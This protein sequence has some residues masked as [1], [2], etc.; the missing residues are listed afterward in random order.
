MSLAILLAT[1]NGE[2]FL[3]EQL[4][5]L[6]AQT[7]LDWVLYVHDDGSTDNTPNI[8]S[9]YALRH[10]NIVVMEYNSS[11]GAM[12]NFLG[13]LQRIDADY[14]MFTDQ[15]DVWHKD[16]VK[17]S[18]ERIHECEKINFNTPIIVHSDLRVVDSNLKLI[19]DSYWRYSGVKLGFITTF[20]RLAVG[21]F[22]TGCTMLFNSKAKEVMVK[23][24]PEA[25]MHDAWLTACVIKKGGIVERIN[26]PLIDY[27][28]HDS[29]SIGALAVSRLNLGYRISHAK[30][31][32]RL[33]KRHYMML[34]S[35]G[36]HS[37]FL[38][39]WNKILY[40]LYKEAPCL[41]QTS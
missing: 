41:E 34:K 18:M 37:I 40:K 7:D 12:K 8:I 31:M 32:F 28:Q 20:E 23:P 5:S 17:V 15:D 27:R 16:K 35:L 11:G 4:D 21:N 38:F 25:Y 2:K 30:Q 33:N 3:Q 14:Y 9:N 22:V 36:Y 39:I 26:T 24:T 13:M 1:Y 6:Y 19:S 10:D 29:N